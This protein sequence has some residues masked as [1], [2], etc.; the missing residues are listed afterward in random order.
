MASFASAGNRNHR[1]GEG[2]GPAKVPA[3]GP[4]KAGY[5]RRRLKPPDD[6]TCDQ[7]QDA[8]KRID[9]ARE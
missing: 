6:A 4:S 9:G 5:A 2:A 1:M 7:P 3:G 8:E